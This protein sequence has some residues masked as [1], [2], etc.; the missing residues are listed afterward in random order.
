MY[1]YIY[2]YMYPHIRVCVC[3][4]IV[5]PALLMPRLIGRVVILGT[6]D[7]ARREMKSLVSRM[8]R[9]NMSQNKNTV[10]ISK[11]SLYRACHGCLDSLLHLFT[12]VC[13]QIRSRRLHERS[14]PY[15]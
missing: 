6:D 13:A 9:E 2:V 11:E 15:C 12:Q 7:K 5:V 3:V 14:I 4:C 10:D 8:L 1:I